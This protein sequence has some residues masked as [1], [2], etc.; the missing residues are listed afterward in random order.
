[1]TEALRRTPLYDEHVELGGK[2]VPFAGWEMPVQYPS[3]ITAEHRAVREAAGLFDVS[4]MG[5]LVVRGPQA[6]DLLQHISINDASRIEVGQAQYSA[7]CLESGGVIDDLLIYRY[8]DRYM[9]VV[10]ASNIDKDHT[11][12]ADRADDFDVEVEDVSDGTAL[13][14][15]QG[16][17]ARE[18]LRPLASIDLGDVTY[19]R[20]REGEVAGVAATISGT[21]YTGEDGFELY[22]AAE[23][24][25]ALWR[26]L[27]ER[28]SEAGLM[29][30]GLGARDSL[31]LEM[32]YALYG[33]DL[34]EEH[35]PLESG[36]GWVTKLDKPS[37]IGRTALV[38]QKEAGVPRKLVGLTVTGRGFPR[39][40]YTI[41]SGGEQVGSIT[42][43]T[44]SPSLG[45]GIAL[46]YVRAEQAAPGTR[47][48]I[49]ARGRALDAVV[50]RPPFYTEG[51]IRR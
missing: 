19:Y 34:D 42:S 47:L 41:R 31:R 15:L 22:V 13:L 39:P 4:H 16:P 18:L 38:A 30:A 45:F 11:W 40:G 36:L 21:G 26:T 28:G 9:L 25:V 1:M 29:P 43:G 5:E 49:D 51:S 46:G 33:N 2:M 48:E 7:M 8:P 3:G 32:G 24:A 23:D 44:V 35:T 14:A 12:V 17:A 10:N 37:F 50:V 27:L 6:L 20:F